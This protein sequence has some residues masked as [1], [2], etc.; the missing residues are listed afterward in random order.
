MTYIVQTVLT[1]RGTGTYR[2]QLATRQ[3]ALGSASIAET[4][5]GEG[6]AKLAA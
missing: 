2:G 3:A 5:I 6:L 4:E 1:E